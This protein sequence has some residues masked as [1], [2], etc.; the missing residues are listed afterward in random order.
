M[1]LASALGADAVVASALEALARD[2]P[3]AV[4]GPGCDPP[5]LGRRCAAWIGAFRRVF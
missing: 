1:L 5:E 4:L 3:E 2:C